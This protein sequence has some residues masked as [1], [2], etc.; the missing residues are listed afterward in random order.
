M[1]IRDVEGFVFTEMKSAID[2]AQVIYKLH[3]PNETS[4]LDS[5]QLHEH[6]EKLVSSATD[7]HQS[8]AQA[9]YDCINCS[10]SVLFL[11]LANF[12][13]HYSYQ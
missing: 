5:I 1:V 6:I 3:K 4:S 7:K 13:G 11:S 10:P 8:F 12:P 9:K 2:F